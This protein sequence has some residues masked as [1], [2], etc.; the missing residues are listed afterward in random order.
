ML[1]T[2]LE[3]GMQLVQDVM[4]GQPLKKAAETR[5]NA[6]GKELLTGVIDNITQQGRGTRVSKWGDAL[7]LS[8][9]R[10]AKERRTPNS[11]FDHFLLKKWQH[12]L[13]QPWVRI[14]VSTFSSKWLDYEG[15]QTGT[16]PVEFV[17]KRLADYIDM[18][19][20]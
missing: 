13:S 1:D 14:Q 16:N 5:A 15:I 3:T 4:N 8:N 10:Y 9:E 18:N 20:T 6:A 2:E 19:K 17:I 12:T 11:T 7:R